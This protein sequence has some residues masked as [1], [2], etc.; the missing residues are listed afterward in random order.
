MIQRLCLQ[1]MCCAWVVTTVVTIVVYPGFA[2][3]RHCVLGY[4]E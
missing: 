4:E 1:R 3:E 2:W